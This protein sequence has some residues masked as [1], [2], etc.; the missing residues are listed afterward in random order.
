MILWTLTRI[1]AAMIEYDS[2]GIA[3]I[4][5]NVYEIHCYQTKSHIL[6]N[7]SINKMQNP[8][9]L[10]DWN[11]LPHTQKCNGKLVS[12]QRGTFFFS[13]S[14]MVQSI[15]RWISPSD[16]TVNNYKIEQTVNQNCA[17]FF[18]CFSKLPCYFQN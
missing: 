17:H 12:V 4:Y 13:Y 10:I 14:F 5:D 8:I 15:D 1:Q 3:T 2:I 18:F 9:M 6:V 16:W 7:Q 11:E